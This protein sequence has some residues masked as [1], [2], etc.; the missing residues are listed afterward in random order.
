M[1]KHPNLSR[2]IWLSFIFAHENSEMDV[3]DQDSPSS[4]YS[5]I[6][7]PSLLWFHYIPHFP[8]KVDFE[9][10]TAQR[11]YGSGLEMAPFTSTHVLLIRTQSHDYI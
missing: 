6:H 2:L 3:S 5:G 1:D 8:C 10:E 9:R 7:A 4:N 11:F